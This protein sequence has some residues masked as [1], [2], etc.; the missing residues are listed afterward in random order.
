[1]KM[2]LKTFAALLMGMAF[3]ACSQEV[4]TFQ[5]AEDPVA[6]TDEQSSRWNEVGTDLN[7]AWGN[8]DISY[9]RSIVPDGGS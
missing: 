2:T 1:M 4:N 5:E 8:T 7:A 9:G 3:H 6:L